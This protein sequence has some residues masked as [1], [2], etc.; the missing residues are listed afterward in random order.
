MIRILAIRGTNTFY[1]GNLDSTAE[2]MDWR[3]C[4]S[5]EAPYG[6]RVQVAYLNTLR[7]FIQHGA[8]DRGTNIRPLCDALEKAIG[9]GWEVWWS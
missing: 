6:G 9:D 8:I 4:M 7:N 2:E 1:V 3:N 5:Y